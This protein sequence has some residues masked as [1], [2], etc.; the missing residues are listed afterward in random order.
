MNDPA[1]AQVQIY[2]L[3]KDNEELIGFMNPTE[4]VKEQIRNNSIKIARFALEINEF[5]KPK[6]LQK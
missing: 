5:Y 6:E 2:R 4:E 3:Y 1:N